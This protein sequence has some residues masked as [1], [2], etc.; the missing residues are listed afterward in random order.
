MLDNKKLKENENRVKKYMTERIIKTKQKPEYVDFFLKN[1]RNFLNSAKAEYLLSTNKQES[2][3][4]GFVDYNGF[5]VVVNSGYYSM[6][7]MVRALLENEGIKI[8]TEHSIHAVTFD[9]L[10]YFFYLSKK[11][12]ARL[13]ESFANAREES[14]EIFGQR[15]AAEMVQDLFHEKNK[16]ATFTYKMGSEIV[17]A[18]AKTSLDRSTKFYDDVRSLIIK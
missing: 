6:F 12:E 9:A 5:I 1:S 17:K 3:R 14:A 4:L 13:I 18:K 8:K 10:V 7:N 15:R 2:E 11:L 16:R